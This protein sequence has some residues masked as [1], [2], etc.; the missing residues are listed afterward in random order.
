[1]TQQGFDRGWFVVAGLFLVLT[2]SS[3]FGFYNLSV[4]IA[5]LAAEQGFAISQVSVAVSLFF[6]VGGVAGIGVAQLLDRFDVRWIMVGGA[7][8]AGVGLG[9]SGYAR[10]LSELYALF[11]LFGVGNAGVSI[12]VST[13]LVTRWFPG[14]QRSVALS[15]ASTGLSMG[16]VIVT[17]ICARL[18]NDAGAVTMMPWFGAA[19]FFC[20]VP[21]VLAVIRDG[22]MLSSTGLQT[23]EVQGWLYRDAVK[24]RFFR[25]I[26]AAYL[27][28]MLS[29]VGGI[30]HLYSRAEIATDYLIA[31]TAVQALSAM[32]IVSRILG[33]FIVQRIS[34]RSFALGNL[35]GQASGLALLALAEGPVLVLAGAGLFGATV[36]NLLMLHP[37]WLAEAF[38]GRAY[39]KIFSVSNAYTV[40]GVGGGPILLGLLYDASGYRLSYGFAAAVS[41]LAAV[42]MFAAGRGPGK[43]LVPAGQ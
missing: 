21:V 1:M 9:L 39:A 13:T 26:T 31:A 28:C 24:S 42:L 6:V 32:S 35:L 33:G 11:L 36:G 23:L 16:G 12:V 3:G 43:S 20:I 10:S 34:L 5:V 4:Y 17:P 8:L 15:V 27:L 18:L 41:L 14:R 40:L 22:R 29:Q 38:G 2:I 25:L 30:S 19:F 37:L 7:A